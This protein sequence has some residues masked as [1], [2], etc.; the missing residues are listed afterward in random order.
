VRSKWMAKRTAVKSV[1][2]YSRS[3]PVGPKQ[4]ARAWNINIE[5]AQQMMEAT[6]QYRVRAVQPTLT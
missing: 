1:K 2:S 4:L 5:K 3:K 6:T